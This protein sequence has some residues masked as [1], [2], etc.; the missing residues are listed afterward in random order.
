MGFRSYMRDCT[1]AKAPDMLQSFSG[2]SL[3]IFKATAL[4]G[5]Q[6]CIRVTKFTYLMTEYYPPNDGFVAK[7][8]LF[9]ENN[10]TSY[11]THCSVFSLKSAC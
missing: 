4:F 1:I 10:L 11:T 2:T 5:E 7:N 9:Y 6:L 3:Y 8:A